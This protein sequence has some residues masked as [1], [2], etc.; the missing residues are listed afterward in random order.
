[1]LKIRNESSHDYDGDIVANHCQSI[2]HSYV[3]KLTAFQ[4]KAEEILLCCQ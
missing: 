3:D 2:I 1:M 4:I